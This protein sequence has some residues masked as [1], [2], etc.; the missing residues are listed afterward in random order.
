LVGQSQKRTAVFKLLADGLIRRGAR[1]PNQGNKSKFSN[2]LLCN[3]SAQTLSA[4][5]CK[6]SVLLWKQYWPYICI[7]WLVHLHLG[8]RRTWSLLKPPKYS[9]PWDA[10]RIIK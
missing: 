2:A 3:S 1:E 6:M 5:R 7:M 4:T 10:K 8:S 9:R